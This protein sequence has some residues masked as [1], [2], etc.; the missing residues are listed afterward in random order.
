MHKLR[1]HYE[2]Q[3]TEEL[4]D[5]AKKDLTDEARVILTDVL[6]KRGVPHSQVGAAR[7]QGV[8]QQEQAAAVEG[9][10]A[11]RWKRLIAFV[12]DVWAVIIGLFVLLSPIRLVSVEF[13]EV[14]IPLVWLGYFL[15]RDSFPGQGLGKRLLRLRT[16]QI[17]S[18]RS[19]TWSQSFSRNIAHLFFVVDALFALGARRMRLGDMLAGT[20]V[21]KS[22]S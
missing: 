16:V 8:A 15:V 10:L 18:D 5:I 12:I 1:E 21:V 20:I 6:V 14:V 2:R 3:E 17:D 11:S 22:G 7:Q 13:H 4:L 9:K 19:C